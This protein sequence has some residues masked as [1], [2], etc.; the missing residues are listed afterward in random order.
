MKRTWIERIWHRTQ[1][2]RKAEARR[3]HDVVLSATIRAHACTVDHGGT[4]CGRPLDT[5]GLCEEHE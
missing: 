1:E 2:K 4:I 3:A 5:Y